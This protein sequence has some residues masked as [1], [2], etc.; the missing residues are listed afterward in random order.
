MRPLW[1]LDTVIVT[2][3]AAAMVNGDL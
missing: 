1:T 3:P 2:S